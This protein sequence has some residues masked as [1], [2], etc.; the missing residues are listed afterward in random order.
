MLSRD[1][2]GGREAEGALKGAVS[3]VQSTD[4]HHSSLGL[5]VTLVHC[6][7]TGQ[8]VQ[9]QDGNPTAAPVRRMCPVL[10]PSSPRNNP[11]TAQTLFVFLR[12]L[13]L[14]R[15]ENDQYHHVTGC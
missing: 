10:P 2:K 6:Y 15:Q 1:G 14:P 9:D 4:C 3:R 13:N 12:L 7:F 8:F 5:D 11:A